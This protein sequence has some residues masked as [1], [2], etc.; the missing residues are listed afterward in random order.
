MQYVQSPY[1]LTANATIEQSLYSQLA[2][3]RQE[4]QPS[5]VGFT[6]QSFS[7]I[8]A[9][10]MWEDVSKRFIVGELSVEEFISRMNSRLK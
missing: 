3:Q 2:A 5:P 6:Y 9:Q 1:P 8:A 10:R 7:G 4:Q